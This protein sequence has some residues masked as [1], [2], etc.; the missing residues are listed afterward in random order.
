MQNNEWQKINGAKITTNLVR[1]L[2]A[3]DICDS[4][5]YSWLTYTVSQDDQNE[6]PLDLEYQ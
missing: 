6:V 1:G 2:L 4:Y 3:Y 5:L